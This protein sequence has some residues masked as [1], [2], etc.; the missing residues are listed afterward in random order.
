MRNVV[1]LGNNTFNLSGKVLFCTSI[2]SLKTYKSKILAK[3]D[4][5]IRQKLLKAIWV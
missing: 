3:E 2:C 5:L 4:C 1:N